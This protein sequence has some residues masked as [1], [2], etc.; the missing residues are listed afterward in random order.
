MHTLVNQIKV[1]TF[2]WTELLLANGLVFQPDHKQKYVYWLSRHAACTVKLWGG[3]GRISARRRNI[4]LYQTTKTRQS[5][6]IFTYTGPTRQAKE[7]NPRKCTRACAMSPCLPQFQNPI[8]ATSC[9]FL[10]MRIVPVSERLVVVTLV[11]P[12]NGRFQNVRFQKVWFQNV[13]FQNVRFT[14]RQV[15]E[16][17]G[18]KTSGCKTSSF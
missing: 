15:Y 13:R 1:S 2:V 10:F 6:K 11:H 16:T 7:G 17:S 9:A 3:G 8:R 18:F 12:Q 14:I 4:L 5:R